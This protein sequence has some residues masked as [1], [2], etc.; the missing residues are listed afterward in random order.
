MSPFFWVKIFLDPY[1]LNPPG[2]SRPDPGF[3]KEACL[4]GGR[5]VPLRPPPPAAASHLHS[6][7]FPVP[8]AVDRTR[9]NEF[10]RI[11]GVEGAEAAQYPVCP[12][13]H[14]AHPP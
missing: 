3:Y 12:Q 8:R 1:F 6:G 9:L 10:G 11:I 7:P 13:T 2:G 14:G 4:Q 5:P